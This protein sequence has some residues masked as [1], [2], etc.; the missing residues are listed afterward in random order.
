MIGQT[1]APTL[2]AALVIVGFA[3]PAVLPLQ[4]LSYRRTVVPRAMA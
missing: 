4:P 1:R 2:L 3:L